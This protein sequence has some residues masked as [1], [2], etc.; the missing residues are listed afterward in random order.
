MWK[1][2][3]KVH[4]H[5]WVMCDDDVFVR[6]WTIKIILLNILWRDKRINLS[7][8]FAQCI[9]ILCLLTILI[10]PCQLALFGYPDWGFSVLFPQLSDKCQ[11]ITRKD[12]AR[13]TI[14]PVSCYLLCSVVI[15][16]VLLFVTFYVVICVVLCT[17]FV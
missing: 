3:W 2:D 5:I 4:T 14:F 7:A 17:V 8:Y 12:G 11:G 9:C 6:T 10:S 1:A 15:C 13:S 16:V